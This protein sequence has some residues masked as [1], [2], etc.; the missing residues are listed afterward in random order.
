MNKLLLKIDQ[1]SVNIYINHGEGKEPTEVVY[2]HIDEVKED[3]SVALS[4][5]NAINLF[6]TNPAE[7]FKIRGLSDL[8]SIKPMEIAL[9]TAKQNLIDNVS[10]FPLEKLVSEIVEAEFYDKEHGWSEELQAELEATPHPKLVEQYKEIYTYQLRSMDVDS[11]INSYQSEIGLEI[12]IK[13]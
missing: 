12:K 11:I 6:H 10:S 4:M 8:I 13:E 9:D 1:E 7:L 5:A 2:W 3:A